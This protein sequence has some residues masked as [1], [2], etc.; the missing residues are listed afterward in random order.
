VRA[1]QAKYALDRR[2]TSRARGG[3]LDRTMKWT[4]GGRSDDVEDQRG[5]SSGGGGGGGGLRLGIGGF[6]VVGILSL[7]FKRNLFS[8]LSTAT[9]PRGTDAP[10]SGGYTSTPD[11]DK[12]V[13]FVSFVLDDIQKTWTAEFQRRGKAYQRAK[14]VL[15]TGE[16]RSACGNADAASGP[17]YCPSNQK[18][19]ID[20]AFY[21]ELKRRFAAPGDFAQAYVIA[22]EIGH[23][24]QNLLGIEPKL[25]QLQHAHPDEANELSVKMELQA[26]CFAGIWG[27]STEQRQLLDVGDVEEALNCAS[28]IGDDRLQ[29]STRGRVNPET[30]THGSSAQRVRWFKKGM[31]SGRIEN[32]DTFAAD[33]L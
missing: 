15:F 18:A 31:T 6:I 5:Q 24:V 13:Q 28:A 7:V 2:L 19:Y 10:S 23:H 32:C 25:R 22:H 1:N 26:D 21:Q 16:V 8:D 12:Q 27:K 3:A 33:S 17:F 20:L 4:P 30:F 14:L 9:S 29:R 11:E